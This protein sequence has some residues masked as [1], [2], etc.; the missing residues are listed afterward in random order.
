MGVYD[1]EERQ[2]IELQRRPANRHAAAFAARTGKTV[3]AGSDTHTLASLGRTYTS[4]PGARDRREFLKG[5]KRGRSVVA[6]S[7]AIIGSSRARCGR[8]ASIFWKSTRGRG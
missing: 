1:I 5:L 6:G 2:H 7:R 3:V 8:S 4:V